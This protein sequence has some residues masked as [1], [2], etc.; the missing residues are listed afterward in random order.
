MKK[1]HGF[2]LL[3][4]LFGFFALSQTHPVAASTT[5]EDVTFQVNKA[6]TDTPSLSNSFFSKTAT[7]T[8]DNGQP[9]TVTLHLEKFASFIK[10]FTIGT[11]DAK[12]TNVTSNTAD[13]TFDIDEQFKTS[14]VTASMSVLN[15]NQKADLVFSKA[16][17]QPVTEDVAFQ[18]NKAGTDTPSLANGF[19]SHVATVTLVDGQPATVTL[20]LEKFASFIKSFTVGTQSAQFTNVTSSTADLTFNLDSQFSTPVVT[21]SMSVLN[22]KQQADL[23]FEKALYQPAT[24][25]DAGTTT[26]PASTDTG[27]TTKPTTTTDTGATTKPTT[28]TDTGATTK[29]TTTTDTGD[30]TK[31]TTTTDASDTT[32]PTTATDTGAT[33]KPTTTTNTGTATKPTTTTDTSATSKP[34]IQITTS[35]STGQSN[36]DVVS[37]KLYQAQDGQLTQTVSAAQQFMSSSAQVVSHGTTTTITLHT[38]GAEY[39][40]S[41]RVA[42]ELGQMT[43]QQGSQADLVFTLKTSALQNA[44]PVTFVLSVPGVAQMTQSAFLLINL[45]PQQ[46]KATTT[47]SATTAATTSATS[48][49]NVRNTV[50]TKASGHAIVATKA[51]QNVTYTVLD[52]SGQAT[53]T[54]NQYFTHSAHIVKE[55]TGYLVYLTV[56]MTAG[57]VQFTPQS[58]NGTSI[59]HLTHT[60]TG[61]QEVWTFAFHVTSATALDQLIPATILMSVPI[62]NI[63]NQSFQIQLAFARQA[64]AAASKTTAVTTSSAKTAAL[65]P[66]TIAKKAAA[67]KA[68]AQ[69]KSTTTG[70]TKALQSA[71]A[72]PQLKKY[73]IGWELLGILLI[74]A[75]MILAAGI[76][77]RRKHLEVAHD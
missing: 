68:K 9:K 28:T 60:T 20:H 16:L 26:D 11:Q 34:V 44:L 69:S 21:A 36:N 31:P 3:C 23:V 17:Y 40:K 56:R 22:M 2:F 64:V 74:D 15:M 77:R 4:L 61:G 54:A 37:A 1:F 62:A 50:L 39:I 38:S 70:T 59:S 35:K 25:T 10:S 30:T 46:A 14:V 48:T 49:S 7:V 76:I 71:Q 58:V 33:T 47:T 66:I 42:G 73:P 12:F 5:T 29:P 18:L 27:D 6:G 52:A 67:S 8:L 13:L 75:L 19:F 55:A 41:M 43:N 72:V 32:D 45:T 65:A 63:S 53:S 57:V 51:E 24:T